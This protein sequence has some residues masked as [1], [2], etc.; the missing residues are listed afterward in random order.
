MDEA[1]NAGWQPAQRKNLNGGKNATERDD[2]GLLKKGTGSP[3]HRRE[4][5]KRAA[6]RSKQRPNRKNRLLEF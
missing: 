1:E 4:G 2:G 6:K 5:D 3:V